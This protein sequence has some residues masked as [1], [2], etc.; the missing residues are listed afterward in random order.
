MIRYWKLFD[1]LNRRDM[2]L[3][4]LRSIISSATVAKLKKGEYI[5]GEVI[6]K[7]CLYLE[8]QPGDI[9][10]VVEVAEE[11]DKNTQIITKRYVPED[12]PDVTIEKTIIE[13]SVMGT[14]INKSD[15]EGTTIRTTIA[16]EVL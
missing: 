14:E 16:E 5:S 8:C 7:I 12:A 4:D 1:L 10:E 15:E 13:Q 6:E 11:I 9:M 2:K 3:S